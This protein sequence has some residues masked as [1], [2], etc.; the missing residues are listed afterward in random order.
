MKGA[1]AT[2]PLHQQS[3]DTDLRERRDFFVN[4]PGLGLKA[5]ASPRVEPIELHLHHLSTLTSASRSKSKLASMTIST[6]IWPLSM[7]QSQ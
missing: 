7:S 2:P 6:V 3:C 1:V 5:S 4:T